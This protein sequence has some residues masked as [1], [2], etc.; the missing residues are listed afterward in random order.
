MRTHGWRKFFGAF[1]A[2][3]LFPVESGQAPI[4]HFNRGMLGF[5]IR[6]SM[7]FVVLLSLAVAFIHSGLLISPKRWGIT[8]LDEFGMFFLCVTWLPLGWGLLRGLGRVPVWA[9]GLLVVLYWSLFLFFFNTSEEL[10]GGATVIYF[11]ILILISG[12]FLPVWSAFVLA[13]AYDAILLQASWHSLLPIRIFDLAGLGLTGLFS[14][15]SGTMLNASYDALNHANLFLEEKVQLRTGELEKSKLRLAETNHS[16]ELEN[17]E[18]A[19]LEVKLRQAVAESEKASRLK[20]QFL[21]NISHEIR[22]PLTSIIGFSYLLQNSKLEPDQQLYAETLRHSGDLLLA[23]IND[24]LD[25]SKI[26][27]EQMVLEKIDFD[28]GAVIGSVCDIIRE[29]LQ[30]KSV[31]LEVEYPRELPRWFQGDPTRFRQILLNLMGNAVKFTPQGMVAVRVEVAGSRRVEGIPHC[32]LLI[33]VQDTGIGIPVEHQRDI[34]S[35]FVQGDGSITRQY[36]GTGLGLA[37]TKELVERMGG[38]IALES[39]PGKGSTFTVRVTLPE[40][41]PT[42]GESSATLPTLQLHGLGVLVVEALQTDRILLGRYLLD[43]GMRLAHVAAFPEEALAWLA[44]HPGEVVLVFSDFRRSERQTAPAFAERVRS[45][46]EGKGVKLIALDGEPGPGNSEAA[47]QAGFDGYLAKPMRQSEF[48]RV[49][50]GVLGDPGRTQGQAAA[51]PLP[52][53]SGLQNKTIL[54]V[55][56]NAVNQLLLDTLLRKLGCRVEIAKNGR[57]AVDKVRVREFDLVLMDLQ[58]PEMDGLQATR[59]IRLQSGAMLPIVALTAHAQ[60]K[61]VEECLQAGMNDY[62]SKPVELDRL[63]E[64]MLE[65]IKR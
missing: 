29:R 20:S 16:L 39:E 27:S 63:K 24:I 7:A 2:W 3:R 56:D 47:R 33:R 54:V 65:W 35:A 60:P 49:V 42:A 1:S 44:Q 13:A 8:E 23:L 57:E 50:L 31:R 58:M 6:G 51:R 43:L 17:R 22:T 9:S 55:E 36:G 62:L 12:F 19:R 15:F 34:F 45:G 64:K 28:L 37:I 48:N 26:E 32:F 40:G 59:A 61:D 41:K 11:A 25:I 5:C 4:G 52:Q 10:A 14:W 21:A 46:A 38:N 30:G 18:R 53:E